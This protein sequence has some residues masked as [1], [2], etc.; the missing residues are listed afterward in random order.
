[1]SVSN[2]DVSSLPEASLGGTWP[3]EGI[4]INGLFSGHLNLCRGLRGPCLSRGECRDICAETER[5]G[6]REWDVSTAIYHASVL[7]TVLRQKLLCSMREEWICPVFNWR[8]SFANS[9]GICRCLS[10]WPF[11]FGC[12]R[13]SL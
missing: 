4:L 11:R 12:H 3:T 1:M 2:T 6:G 9:S 5:E 7:I 8:I 10:E 13:C